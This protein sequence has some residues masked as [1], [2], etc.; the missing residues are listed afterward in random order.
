M[1]FAHRYLWITINKVRIITTKLSDSIYTYVYFIMLD[2]LKKSK[3]SLSNLVI[4]KI[5]D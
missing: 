3:G 5:S 2:C 4:N 1:L